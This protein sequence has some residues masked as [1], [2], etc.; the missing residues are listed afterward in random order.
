MKATIYFLVFLTCY[1]GNNYGQKKSSLPLNRITIEGEIPSG[2]YERI[3]GSNDKSKSIN[4][5]WVN[6]DYVSIA[7]APLNPDM[8]GERGN[9]KGIESDGKIKWLLYT[10]KNLLLNSPYLKDTYYAN[11][12]DSIFI[13]YHNGEPAFSGRGA[14]AFEVQRKLSKLL[15]A[16]SPPTK[17]KF[18]VATL[19]EYFQWI[20]YL[21][22]QIAEINSFLDSHKNQVSPQQFELIKIAWICSIEEERVELFQRLYGYSLKEGQEQTKPL[23]GI[24]SREDLN[25]IWDTTQKNSAWGKWL[26]VFPEYYGSPS[27]LFF[28]NRQAVRRKFNFDFS[29]DSLKSK[30]LRVQAYY[31]EAKKSFKGLQREKLLTRI[32]AEEVIAELGALSPV[33]Q[34]LLTDYYSLKGLPNF[35]YWIKLYYEEHLAY[36]Q[37]K[38]AY[39]FSVVG[40]N[41]KPF[42]R[43]ELKGKVALL[44]FWFTGCAG[45]KQMTPALS[46]VE[47]IF[48][49][50]TN[51]VFLSVSIDKNRKIW[52][53]SVREAKYTTG[54]AINVYTQGEGADHDMVKQFKIAGYPELILLDATGKFVTTEVPDPRSEKGM[55]ELMSLIINESKK[56]TN[57]NHATIND[58]PY[59][60]YNNK[61]FIAH[62]INENNLVSRENTS[63]LSVNTDVP[64]KTFVVKLKHKLE[65]EPSVYAQ[66]EKLLAL[67]DIEGNFDALRL[68]LQNNGVIDD[69]FNWTFGRGHLVI[70]GDVFDRGLQV[71]ECLWLIYSLEE[72]AKLAGGYVHFILG[73][74]ELMNLNNDL[75]YA[76]QKYKANAKLIGVDYINLYNE[77][78]ELGRWLRTKNLVEKVGSH[79]IVHGGIAPEFMRMPLTIEEINH[80]ARP[81]YSRRIDSTNSYLKT[82]FDNNTS[83]VWFRGFYSKPG[84]EKNLPTLQQVD[85]LLKIYNVNKIITGHTIV[86]QDITT[87]F[88]GRII[89]LDTPH[90]TGKSAALLCEGDVYYSVTSGG[91]KVRLTIP[92][93]ELT[94][95]AD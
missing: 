57:K 83:P 21:D 91:K 45:C 89:N 68:L 6:Y 90:A 44:D 11:P 24:T 92:K 78:S 87:W 86:A 26:R 12:G 9:V 80:L 36:T 49:S 17:N 14:E 50:D 66:P 60:L 61:S 40:L 56:A 70:A 20:R 65:P 76:Q 95:K 10:S 79:L 19:D 2:F 3:W 54:N 8:P 18:T 31:N 93:T 15:S 62:S 34:S 59:V 48:K 22:N 94:T 35:K 75:R 72:K 71:T 58:G 53:R 25:I 38:T 5:N 51:V 16:L 32:L 74:H 33:T 64:G 63:E 30:P 82:I 37:S 46:K 52:E 28:F 73:N 42:T 39:D 88:Q 43:N 67:S 1:C 85:S 47:E 41:G 23:L 7:S 4:L 81:Y 84:E 27:Y 69:D 77:Q 55:N 29:H 13:S